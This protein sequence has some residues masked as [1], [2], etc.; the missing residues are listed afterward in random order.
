[1]TGERYLVYA[2]DALSDQLPRKYDQI[3]FGFQFLL[4]VVIGVELLNRNILGSLGY[5]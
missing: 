3:I 1:M 4:D 2:D 5:Y